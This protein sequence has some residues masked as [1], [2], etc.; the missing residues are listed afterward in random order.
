MKYENGLSR[1]KGMT[2]VSSY[3]LAYLAEHRCDHHVRLFFEHALKDRRF[4]H[5]L[6]QP[7]LQLQLL[8]L[9]ASLLHRVY[10]TSSTLFFFGCL[11]CHS[12][13]TS[14]LSNLFVS[15]TN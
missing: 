8:E 14:K 4:L 3:L 15:A 9:G 13:T 6:G 10:E 2:I 1:L 5:D 7:L 11:L 12:G